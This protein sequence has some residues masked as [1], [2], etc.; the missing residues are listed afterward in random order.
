MQLVLDLGIPAPPPAVWPA[1]TPEER[2]AAMVALARLIAKAV[3]V[4]EAV[5]EEAGDD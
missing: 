2:E 4:D 5:R 1:I 3:V